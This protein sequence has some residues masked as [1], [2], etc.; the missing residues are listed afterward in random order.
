MD[1]S[2]Q[3][4]QGDSFQLKTSWKNDWDKQVR[5]PQ[6]HSVE[7]FHVPG[8]DAPLFMNLVVAQAL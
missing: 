4:S 2:R 7:V 6:G 5:Q 8:G 1:A 3:R